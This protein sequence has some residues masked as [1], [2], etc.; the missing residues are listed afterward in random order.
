MSAASKLV[1]MWAL[2]KTM[3]STTPL[4]MRL[5][6]GVVTITI[7]TIFSAILVTVFILGSIWLSYNL[8]VDAQIEPQIAALVIASILLALIAAAALVI[9]GTLRN[10]RHVH[11]RFV[12]SQS[13]VAT[14]MHSVV[15][16]FL[17]GLS[18]PPA[19]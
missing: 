15:D 14:R 7:L 5:L 12:I 4:L 16:A 11:K 13:P 3:S 2:G 8:L 18:T 17:E 10:L 6:A 1:G 9:R 19:R